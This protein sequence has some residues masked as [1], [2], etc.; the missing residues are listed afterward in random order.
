M[1]GQDSLHVAS[2]ESFKA[3]R[4]SFVTELNINPF[5]GNLSLNNALNQIKLRYFVSDQVALRMGFS[6]NSV[7]DNSSASSPYG[8][9]PFTNTEVR[10]STTLSFNP[11]FEKHFAGTKRLSPYLGVEAML[12]KKTSSH[13]ITNSNSSM[14]IEGGWRQQFYSNN[15][16]YPVLTS[17]YA[18]RAFFKYGLNLITGFDFYMSRHFYF[19]YEITFGFSNTKYA[20]IDTSTVYTSGGNVPSE[21]VVVDLDDKSFSLGPNLINGIRL[22]YAF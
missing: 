14:T 4:H 5:Q 15:P 11:G 10:R 8:T 18:E 20:D 12:A 7:K 19:G 1:F 13:E 6:A 3:K 9:N 16:N 22:G 17:T 2:D 21:S